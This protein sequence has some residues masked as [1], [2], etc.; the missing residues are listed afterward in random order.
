M[1]KFF[2]KFPGL[3]ILLFF[4]GAL[5]LYTVVI[6]LWAIPG[7]I[8]VYLLYKS[9]IFIFN[10][11]PFKT[12]S[13]SFLEFILGYNSFI[14]SLMGIFLLMLFGISVYH[15]FFKKDKI[16]IE[17]SDL[18]KGAKKFIYFWF[19]AN[20]FIL[21]PIV[22]FYIIAGALSGSSESCNLLVCY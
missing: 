9:S 19:G 13:D 21:I 22:G 18:L 16:S 14:L 2:D 1:Y 11:A 15:H 8:L 3:G 7:L 10:A 6:S 17:F 4:C 20:V 5:A 12:N